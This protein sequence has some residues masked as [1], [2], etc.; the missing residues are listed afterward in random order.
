MES[1]PN[2]KELEMGTTA[3]SLELQFRPYLYLSY[4]QSHQYLI[5]DGLW[6]LTP[7]PFRSTPWFVPPRH[8]YLAS[9]E[10]NA[11]IE[12][13]DIPFSLSFQSI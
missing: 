7:W 12:A 3:V 1:G 8:L 5:G 13:Q 6:N 9:V 2:A 10:V 4:G 11:V